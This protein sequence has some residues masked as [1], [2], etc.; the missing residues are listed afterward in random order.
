MRHV[1]NRGSAR[2]REWVAK[3]GS[4]RLGRPGRVDAEPRFQFDLVTVKAFGELLK[5]A[6]LILPAF[7]LDFETASLDHAG[8]IILLINY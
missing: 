2:L 8:Y 5:V 3:V 6:F 7:C 4:V 1:R